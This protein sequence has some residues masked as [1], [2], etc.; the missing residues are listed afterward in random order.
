MKLSIAFEPGMWRGVVPLF[1]FSLIAW[2]HHL[3]H[4]EKRGGGDD[5]PSELSEG[6]LFRFPATAS[7]FVGR[8]LMTAE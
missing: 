6:C 4:D 5:T 1:P 2:I 8:R 3:L 7:Y